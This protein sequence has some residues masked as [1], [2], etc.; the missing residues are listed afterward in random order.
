MPRE[1]SLWAGLDTGAD[2][3]RLCVVDADLI[4]I[5]EETLLSDPALIAGALAALGGKVEDIAV[6]SATY[7]IHLV[8]GLRDLGFRVSIFHTPQVARFL[9]LRRNKTD[10]ND[11]SGLAELAKLRLPA[12]KPVHL[13]S[14]DIQRMRTKLQYRHR[15]LQQRLACE[16]MMRSMFRLEGGRLK[17][18]QSSRQMARNVM[19]EVDRL[20]E[21]R[22]IDLRADIAP[23]LE[24]AMSIRR[25]L[26]RIDKDLEDWAR[27]NRICAM[28]LEIPG[29][30]PLT[31]VSFYTA[32]EDPWRFEVA[33]NVGAY[34]GLAP[35][36]SQSGATV[37][38]GRISKKGSRLT[39][40][41]LVSAATVMFAGQIKDCP[42]KQWGIAVAAR[43]GKA[44]ARVAV[45]RRLAV[46]M[47][48]MWKSGHRYDGALAAPRNHATLR[49]RESADRTEP[50]LIG[51]ATTSMSS[52]GLP[53]GKVACAGPDF[54]TSAEA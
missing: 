8:R 14:P 31:A 29:V 22:G 25:Y 34:L 23:L 50:E 4:S 27:G 44:K 36:V 53:V 48:A 2:V 52:L 12:I 43:A 33:T 42:L 17:G 16:G 1:R 54:A 51:E 46:I 10:A 47:L 40:T 5:L 30:G 21:E 37:H 11:A 41:H 45:A 15:L 7:S 13:K 26:E 49:P 20:R 19:A 18:S 24:L 9:R 3:S 32:I 39:R 35:L 28:F 38:H 6:E